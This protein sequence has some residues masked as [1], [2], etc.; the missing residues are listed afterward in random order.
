[1]RGWFLWA[2]CVC[3]ANGGPSVL[4]QECSSAGGIERTVAELHS[5]YTR[6]GPGL[7]AA[8]AGLGRSFDVGEIAV[9]EDDGAGELIYR[10]F[11]GDDTVD[12]PAVCRRFY[13]THRDDF[14]FLT[15]FT[16]FPIVDPISQTPFSAYSLLVNNDIPGLHLPDIDYSADFGSAGNLEA[17]LNMN[18][19]ADPRYGRGPYERL[20]GNN[21]STMSLLAHE[22][23]HRWGARVQVDDDPGPRV[24]RSDLLLGRSFSH[25]SFYLDAPTRMGC[26]SLEG[27][28]WQFDGAGSFDSVGATDGYSALDQYLMG[29][30]AAAEVP[31]FFVVDGPRIFGADEPP[32]LGV[33]TPGLPHWFTIQDVTAVEGRRFAGSRSAA[34]SWRQ[35]FVLV[36]PHGYPSSHPAELQGLINHLDAV[37]REWEYY[38]F[39]S[40]EGR[41]SI[42][43]ELMSVPAPLYRLYWPARGVHF[44]TSSDSEFFSAVAFDGFIPEGTEGY[45]FPTQVAGAIPV[46]RLFQPALASHLY[47]TDPF[48]WEGV[49][50]EAGFVPE[51]VTGYL[52]PTPMP[53][54]IPLYRLYHAGIAD[55]FYTTN[56][57]D[58]EAAVSVGYVVESILGYVLQNDAPNIALQ[59]N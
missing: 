27:N 26:S 57:K 17:V 58:L 15:V 42:H 11:W 48:E 10:T 33:Q 55:H 6:Q 19:F 54:T 22:T 39:E 23:G 56:L 25:W 38:F 29:I 21:D 28:R 37:R 45:L 34:G 51:G 7:R 52:Y 12:I 5:F 50:S 32:L 49:I 8:D 24:H 13:Q 4:A 36:V 31:P 53:R 2:L 47:T 16:A 3:C 46:Y 35:A 14:D 9:V 40:S 41:A 20:P 59:P 1:M 30:R 43:T 18:C 44:Y